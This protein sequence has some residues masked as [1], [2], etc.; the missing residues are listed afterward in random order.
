MK[1]MRLKKIRRQCFVPGCRNTDSVIVTRSREGRVGVVMCRECISD[2]LFL[3]FPDEA[4]DEKDSGEQNISKEVGKDGDIS[5][6][7]GGLE[8]GS[9]TPNDGEEIADGADEKEETAPSVVGEEA[10]SEDAAVSGLENSDVGVE[11][12]KRK[13]S[14]KRASGTKGG[15]RV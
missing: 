2:L 6:G 1:E 14:G 9:E 13:S 3:A 7:K 8:E 4:S 12:P 5:D 10:E 15:K 11:K